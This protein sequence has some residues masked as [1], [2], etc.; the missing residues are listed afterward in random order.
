LKPLQHPDLG[1][2]EIGGWDNKF[3][4]Q[5]PPPQYLKEEI[6]KYIPWM[7]YLAGMSP[8]IDVMH[9]VQQIENS[10]LFQINVTV[11]N[12]GYLPTN[13]TQRALEAE[14]AVPVRVVIELNNAELVS[15]KSRVD[16]GHLKG[17]RDVD[18]GSAENRGEV[19]WIIKTLK[20]D[21]GILLKVISEKGGNKS[22]EVH[23][24]PK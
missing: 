7:L 3:T 21:A 14:I 12:N 1:E 11:T 20:S 6:E 8:Q 17:S 2:V 5:N 19:E 24:K 13:I 18:A 16:V 15:G 10:E 23:L 22:I 9:K 4:F